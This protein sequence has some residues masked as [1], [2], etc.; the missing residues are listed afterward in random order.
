M[1]SLMRA[2]QSTLYVWQDPQK[3]PCSSNRTPQYLTR[4][5]FEWPSLRYGI[6]S[7]SLA[8]AIQHVLH[9]MDEV[10][11]SCCFRIETYASFFSDFANQQFLGGSCLS[12]AF[13]GTSLL[14]I[15]LISMSRARTARHGHKTFQPVEPPLLL[16]RC[17]VVL[18]DR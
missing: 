12:H 14:N 11:A 15:P 16:H 7:V 18:S 9:A 17:R 10:Y 1:A 6:S 2:P 3:D 8:K 4:A 5:L 13:S